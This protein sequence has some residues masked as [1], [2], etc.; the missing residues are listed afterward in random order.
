MAAIFD[1]RGR[2]LNHSHTS[3]FFI[4]KSQRQLIEYQWKPLILLSKY[5]YDYWD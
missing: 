3:G 2:N 1:N 4:P 5:V